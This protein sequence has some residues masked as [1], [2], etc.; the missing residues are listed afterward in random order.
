MVGLRR[1]EILELLLSAIGQAKLTGGVSI[2]PVVPFQLLD[3]LLDYLQP[4]S[5]VVDGA[6]VANVIVRLVAID[7]T[8][9]V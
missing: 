8:Y 6:A 7:A 9:T 2:R 1:I 4:N 5:A 3:G